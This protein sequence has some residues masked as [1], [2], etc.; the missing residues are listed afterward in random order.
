V[1]LAEVPRK[2]QQKTD[3]DLNSLIVPHD[4]DRTPFSIESDN[5]LWV[6]T[7]SE[8]KRLLQ[9]VEPATGMT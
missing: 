5:E 8:A 2:E 6:A 7:M 3:F 4:N 1:I 9:V